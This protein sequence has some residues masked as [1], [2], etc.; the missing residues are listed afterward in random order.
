MR[1]TKEAIAEARGVQDEVA[2]LPPKGCN[3]SSVSD[4]EWNVSNH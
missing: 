2:A 4:F 3:M 1:L